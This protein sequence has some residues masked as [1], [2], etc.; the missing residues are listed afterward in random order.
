MLSNTDTSQRTIQSVSRAIAILRCFSGGQE[1]RLSEICK[2]V[3]LHKSTTSGIVNTLKAEGF[4]EQDPHTGKLQL[5]L[6]L[7]ALAVNARRN[8][9]LICEPYL[10]KLL[11]LS[12]ET[13]NLAVLDAD[14]SE[15]VYIAKKESKQSI[16][17]S[18]SVGKRAPVY[19]TAIGKAILAH[20]DPI[21]SNELI[22]SLEL[23]P[24]TEKTTT[25]KTT[26]KKELETILKCGYAYDDEEFERDVICVAVPL[27]NIYG[28]PIGAISISGPVMRIDSQT[29]L[30][31]ASVLRN[32]VANIGMELSRLE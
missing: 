5:G 20:M 21:K 13:V 11:E 28:E 2:I 27:C 29:R 24:L 22:D 23:I 30:N 14:R 17:I 7:F 19:C 1:R 6:E 25:D 18:T 10:N 12:G 31:I 26:L 15:V 8:L 9:E 4:L 3:N 32:E 16:R